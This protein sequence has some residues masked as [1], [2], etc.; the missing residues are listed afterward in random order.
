MQDFMTQ[1]GINYKGQPDHSLAEQRKG[2]HGKAGGQPVLNNRKA[3]IRIGPQ[4]FFIPF[5]ILFC[6]CKVAGCQFL[7]FREKIGSQDFFFTKMLLA[8][9]I[10][11][12]NEI[13]AEQRVRKTKCQLFFVVD[14]KGNDLI[15]F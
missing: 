10:R 11:A 13:Y 1:G 12:S 7:V 4:Q 5:Q 14:L 9:S 3:I 6:L 2:G 8:D 15:G